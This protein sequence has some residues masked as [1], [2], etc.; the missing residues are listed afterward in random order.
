M[1]VC[2]YVSVG[3]TATPSVVVVCDGDG[4]GAGGRAWMMDGWMGACVCVCVCVCSCAVGCYLGSLDDMG[5]GTP[6]SSSRRIRLSLAE[7]SWFLG[8]E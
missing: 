4:G 6:A 8:R 5:L 2:M 1:Y 7:D 3:G